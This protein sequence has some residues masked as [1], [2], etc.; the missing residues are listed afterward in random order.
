MN[1]AVRTLHWREENISSRKRVWLGLW[2]ICG[3]LWEHSPVHSFSDSLTPSFLSLFPPS[4]W[5]VQLHAGIE[6]D[7]QT[8]DPYSKIEG[9]PKCK[10]IVILARLHPGGDR[11]TD[12]F[13]Y[14]VSSDLGWGLN[15]V[16][17][18]SFTIQSCTLQVAAAAEAFWGPKGLSTWA[19]TQRPLRCYEE[20]DCLKVIF[21]QSQWWVLYLVF[22]S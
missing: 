19:Q 6:P 20:R 7:P 22:L 15:S 13:H 1:R 18:S 9:S 12:L 10:G 8:L 11:V 2:V 14:P 16:R 5:K 3:L 21:S 17:P 4:L